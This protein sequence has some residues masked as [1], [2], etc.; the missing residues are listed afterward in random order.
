M[1]KGPAG[2][3]AYEVWVKAVE[4]GE[5]DWNEAT[6]RPGFFRYL[7]GDKGDPG[8]N[9]KSAY[10]QWVD[11][12]K[13]AAGLDN[14]HT[15]EAD[16][17][18][19]DETDMD[20]FYRYLMGED[21]AP[22]APG[23]PGS[24]GGTPG[25]AGLSAYELWKADVA[26]G[27]DNPHTPQEDEWPKNKTDMA[28]FYEY[29]TGDT[30]SQGVPGL[31]AYDDWQKW[32][33]GGGDPKWI[34]GTDPDDFFRYLK[35]KDGEDGID[36]VNGLDGPGGMDGLDGKT[37]YDLW[38]DAVALGLADPHNPGR[39]WPKDKI[40]MNDF[41]RYMTGK[42]GADG[43]SAYGQWV[44]DVRSEEGLDNPHNPGAKWPVNQVTLLDFWHY[45]RGEDGED[46][47]DGV[48]PPSP[49]EE[50]G[51]NKPVPGKANVIAL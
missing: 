34:E 48:V 40:A 36:G 42:D 39:D 9:G 31:S 43:L 4:D 22:G 23:T 33:D 35:G 2:D 10:D 20:D 15:P 1:P 25:P 27:L 41:Y 49:G 7:K 21:G 6:D 19:A 12:V 14:P 17:W 24:G 8:P 29:L 46:G 37:A 5:I 38:K 13:S 45:L 26:N 51:D 18:P 32:I 11:D 50:G 28:D 30:G 3:S 16:R 47:R 44:L